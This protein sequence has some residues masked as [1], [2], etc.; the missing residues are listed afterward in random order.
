MR[1][2][3]NFL[4]AGVGGQ[5]T[6]LASDVLVNVGLAAGYQAK[7]AEVHGMSQRGGSVTGHVRWGKVVYSPLVGA[8]EVDVYLA[9]EKAEALRN[10][11]Q[12]RPGALAV[13]NMQAIEPVTVTSGGQS[14]PDDEALRRGVAQVTDRAV[15]VDGAAIAEGLGNIRAANV[16]LLGALSA[17]M[18]RAGLAGIE[19]APETWLGVITARVPAKYAELNRRAFEAGRAA[20]GWPRGVAPEGR[21]PSR[22]PY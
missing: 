2:T 15:Y 20:V 1:D 18:E 12:L 7:Q 19:L 9:F 11:G 10:L 14:Y 4:L 6:I 21:P 17:L 16:V 3:I 5:G 13:V 8:G 22:R